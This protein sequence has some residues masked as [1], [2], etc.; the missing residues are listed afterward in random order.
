MQSIIIK[1]MRDIL[2]GD[3][4]CKRGGS[5]RQIGI[6]VAKLARTVTVRWLLDGGNIR[7]SRHTLETLRNV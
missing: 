2:V 7:I 5:H 3:K 6:V 4:V 1:K